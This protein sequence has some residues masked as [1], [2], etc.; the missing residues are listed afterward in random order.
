MSAR[1]SRTIA[2]WGIGFALAVCLHGAGVAALLLHWHSEQGDV[3]NAPVVTVELAAL[4]VAPETAGSELPAGPQQA[5]AEPEPA[6]VEPVEKIELPPEPKAEPLQAV[7]PPKP[8]EKQPEKKPR[9]RASLASAPVHT[10]QKA[11][12]AA[13]PAPGANAQDSSAMPTWKSLLVAALE[14]NKRYP[15]EAEARH[16]SGT[17]LLGFSVD[18]G[19][20]VHGG[21]IIR[22]SGSPALDK[23][24]L[25]MLSR[26]A[27]L[28]P[29]PPGITGGAIAIT[30]PIRYNIR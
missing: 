18:R 23:A 13:A 4:P 27:P 5:E 15:A 6:P 28:P 16:E 2:F 25:A 29:P 11:D 20:G 30:V 21:R 10:E 26:A 24:T 19:G 9:Q 22:S 7:M 17:A 12:R 14:R 8:V 3:A 1:A